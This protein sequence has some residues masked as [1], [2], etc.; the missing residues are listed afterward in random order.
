MAGH[1][2][3]QAFPQTEADDRRFHLSPFKHHDLMLMKLETHFFFK[4]IQMLG[5]ET[6]I[7]S[8]SKAI[9]VTKKIFL[10]VIKK[11]F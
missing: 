10:Q 5:K 3:D 9:L 2:T 7:S 11:M 6:T 8:Q 1:A 4:K